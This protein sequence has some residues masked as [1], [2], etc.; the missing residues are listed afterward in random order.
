MV[1]NN[2]AEVRGIEARLALRWYIRIVN[3]GLLKGGS[4]EYEMVL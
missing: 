4:L 2:L 3:I 1:I